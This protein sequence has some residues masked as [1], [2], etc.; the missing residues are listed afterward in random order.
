MFLLTAA[1]AQGATCH[2]WPN[3]CPGTLPYKMKQTY[4]MNASTIIYACNYSGFQA[5]K[6]VAGWG[7]TQFDWSN[8]RVGW[9]PPFR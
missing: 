6:T 9:P 4:L 2:D 7:V 3:T 5:P 8:N 1:V